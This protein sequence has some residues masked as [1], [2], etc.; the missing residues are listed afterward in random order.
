M[1]GMN[2]RDWQLEEKN[3]RTGCVSMPAL[4]YA[5]DHCIFAANNIWMHVYASLAGMMEPE[6]ANTGAGLHVFWL[7]H[8][9]WKLN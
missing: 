3:A 1:N 6:N 9:P 5:L 7:S 2:M 8:W 4:W